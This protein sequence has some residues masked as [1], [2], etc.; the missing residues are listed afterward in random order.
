VNVLARIISVVFHPL[1]MGT[2]LLGL[3]A[4]LLPA[5]MYPVSREAQPLFL[6]L[7]FFITFVIP[8]LMVG[9]L[10]LLGS[11][12]SFTMEN[13]QERIFPF[14]LILVLYAVF[15]YMLTYKNRFGFDDNVFKFLLII[16]C[17]VL[18]SIVFTLFYK[19]SVHAIGIMG[20]VG[21]LI[22]LNKE[23]DNTMLLW[24]TLGTVLLAGIVMSARLQLN[25]HTP[26]QVLVGALAGFL[27]G[28]FGMIVLFY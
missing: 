16:D 5:A 23:S 25:A 19:V 20:L 6:G 28:F 3:L 8:V 14:F 12:Q 27:T 1:L 26:R 18:V 13:R 11:I 10:K 9:S 15:T 4:L 22:P 2:Y 21:I 7:F 24:T 17:L